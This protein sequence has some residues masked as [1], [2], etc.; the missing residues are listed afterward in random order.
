MIYANFISQ[1]ELSINMWNSVSSYVRSA[2]TKSSFKS[3][4]DE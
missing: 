2:N 4:L 3:R 1:T